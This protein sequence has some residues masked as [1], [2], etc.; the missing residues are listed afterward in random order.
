LVLEFGH[1]SGLKVGMIIIT[2]PA[3]MQEW[4]R[5]QKFSG[6][7]IGL[8]PTMGY[9]HEGHLSLVRIARAKVD[10]VVV[11]LFVNPTQFRPQD[12]FSRYPRDFDRDRSLCEQERVAVL[13]VPE[14]EAMYLESYSVYVNEESLS[15]GLCGASRPGH[16]RGVTTVV[17]KLFNLVLPDLAVFGEKDAQQ[18]RVIRRLVRDLNFPVTIVPGP[19]VREPDGVAMSSRNVLLN[20]EERRQAA[21]L[22]RSLKK[23]AEAFS[24][25]ERDAGRIKELVA[26]ELAAA[27][28]G[29]IDYIE[30]VDDETLSPIKQIKRKALLAIAVYFS[31]MRLIDNVVLGS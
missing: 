4:S 17:A 3:E 5:R 2:S 19:I 30:L 1:S 28:L 23:A 6:K 29:R 21:A 24:A 12:D 14:S 9:L 8:V 20:P 11:S 10:L 18:L 25:G 13:F 22:N 15:R 31:A 27:P 7:V 16:F 26:E